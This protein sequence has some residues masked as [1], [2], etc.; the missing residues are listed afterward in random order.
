MGRFL[1]CIY[2]KVWILVVFYSSCLVFAC[3]TLAE[4]TIS[5]LDFRGCYSFCVYFIPSFAIP[6]PRPPNH[7]QY[8]ITATLPTLTWSLPGMYGQ[9][10]KL[11]YG[12]PGAGSQVRAGTPSS[13][14]PV[15]RL[16]V[17]KL[18]VGGQP[19]KVMFSWPRMVMR[20]S[21]SWK[22]KR[23]KPLGNR[24]ASVQGSLSE[25]KAM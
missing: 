25:K 18:S 11:S 24:T 5:A 12:G 20:S 21:H 19:V 13:A 17:N 8:S 3:R 2:T 7:E 15:G 6:S 16:W 10:L 22:P 23:A 4:L 1:G 9:K 14:T